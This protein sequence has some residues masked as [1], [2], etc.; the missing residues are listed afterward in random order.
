MTRRRRERSA[1][2]VYGKPRRGRAQTEH[3]ILECQFLFAR[4]TTRR[5]ETTVPTNSPRP[6]D[7]RA[8]FR[9]HAPRRP[10]FSRVRSRRVAPSPRRAAP[11]TD[12]R[13][14]AKKRALPRTT[15]NHQHNAAAAPAARASGRS[16]L[17]AT[18]RRR[19]RRPR[20]PARGLPQR[21]VLPVRRCSRRAKA[22][23]ADVERLVALWEHARRRQG[24]VRGCV[25]GMRERLRGSVQAGEGREPAGVQR[26]SSVAEERA[27]RTG[28][29][30]ARAGS[31]RCAA[32]GR[33]ERAS[34]R[35]P[36]DRSLC[37]DRAIYRSTCDRSDPI[38]ID[39]RRRESFPFRSFR[40]VRR[41]PSS[42][43]P[44]LPLLTRARI[45]PLSRGI[46]MK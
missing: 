33:D 45:L 28:P 43:R 27:G 35:A 46:G 44:V 14:A 6:V 34:E 37:L 17:E 39:R 2:R 29:G 24:R 4:I 12:P 40:S 18:K 1:R 30:E 23:A 9:V 10:R 20:P 7:V 8:R 16:P 22:G 42:S 31:V 13:A 38:A 11:S 25:R 5:D 3:S 26:L 36:R 32:R 41:D 21:P 15:S 19:V